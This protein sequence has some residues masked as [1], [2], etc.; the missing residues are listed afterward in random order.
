MQHSFDSQKI[1]FPKIL[2]DLLERNGHLNNNLEILEISQATQEILSTKGIIGFYPLAKLIRLKTNNQI[3]KK[4]ECI[5]S[6]DG[7]EIIQITE[8]LST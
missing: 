7:K 4:L 2:F 1:N 8:L 3:E 6:S 5:I